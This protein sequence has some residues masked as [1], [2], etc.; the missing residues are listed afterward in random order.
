VHRLREAEQPGADNWSTNINKG[1]KRN[2]RP[3]AWKVATVDVLEK[4][5]FVAKIVVYY[6]SN[7][8]VIIVLEGNGSGA[9]VGGEGGIWSPKGRARRDSQNKFKAVGKAN[10]NS[11]EEGRW[12][13]P[14][15]ARFSLLNLLSGELNQRKIGASC[16]RKRRD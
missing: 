8:G 4:S 3:Y 7:Q 1:P 14:R 10:G 12:T 11:L 15:P 2:V 16:V 6:F 9:K 13:D 5:G